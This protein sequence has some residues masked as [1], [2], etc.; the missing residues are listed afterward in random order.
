MRSKNVTYVKN[1]VR[2]T[3]D[4]RRAIHLDGIRKK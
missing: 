2:D 1:N 3:D 4:E